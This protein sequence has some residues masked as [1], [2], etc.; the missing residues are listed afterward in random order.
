MSLRKE[1]SMKTLIIA[2]TAAILLGASLMQASANSPRASNA[3]A[4]SHSVTDQSL[5]IV[6]ARLG[7]QFDQAAARHK[8][9]PNYQQSIALSV[10]GKTLCSGN[11]G[12]AGIEYMT[13]AMRMI[14]IQ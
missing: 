5:S 14:G 9:D 3:K 6:C 10:E 4:N 8:L 11:E 13:S 12:A 2:T 7:D 1:T